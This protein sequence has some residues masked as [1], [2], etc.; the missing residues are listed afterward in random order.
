ME[1]VPSRRGVDMRRLTVGYATGVLVAAGLMA[2][3]QSIAATS[4]ADHWML[5]TARSGHPVT[6]TIKAPEISMGTMSQMLIVGV[7][8][9]TAEVDDQ[10]LP[11]TSVMRP[12]NEVDSTPGFEAKTLS[13]TF[14]PP[15][16]GDYRVFLMAS[17]APMC[18]SQRMD[19]MPGTTTVDQV[20]IVRVS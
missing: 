2:G 15:G 20:G 19:E 8:G 3:S 17:D 10:V 5:A 16:K 4:S 9:S 13:V 1:A 12:V 14:S 11:A 18:H 6:A 7:P